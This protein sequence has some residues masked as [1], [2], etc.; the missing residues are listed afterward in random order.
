MKILILFPI[1]ILLVNSCAPK[2]NKLNLNEQSLASQILQE[3]QEKADAQEN[4]LSTGFSNSNSAALRLEENRSI[5]PKN[6]PLVLDI[7]GTRDKIKPVNYSELGNSIE[8]IFLKHPNDSDYFKNGAS[9]LFTKSNIITT[10]EKGIARFDLNGQ[11][12]E[13]I[14]IDG[15]KFIVDEQRGT[16]YVTSKIMDVYVGSQGA[17]SAIGDKIFYKY[18]NNPNEESFLME[19]DVSPGKQSLMM[20]GQSEN[21]EMNGK[22]EIIAQLPFK[23]KGNLTF[24]DEDH[25]ITNQRKFAS[26]KSGVFMTVHSLSGDTVCTLKDYDPVTNFTSSVYRGV[27]SGDSYKL[28]GQSYFRQNFNDTIYRFE[29]TNRIVPV[30]VIDLGEKGVASSEEAITP[31]FS[32]EDK[33]VYNEIVETRG[34]LFFLYTQDYSCPNSARSGSLKYNRFVMNKKTGEQFHAYIDA[35]P[36]MPNKKMTWPRPPQTNVINDLDFGPARWPIMQ[37]E[38][39]LIY[40]QFNGKDIK[41]H[42]QNNRSNTII[43]N[44]DRLENISK[45]CSDNDLLIMVIK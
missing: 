39:G 19:Y 12:I 16:K 8:Y 14:C 3:E 32:L 10:T 30:Y 26:S 31:K 2:K 7:T 27:E 18:V 37:T 23:M 35:A 5:D 17:V 11:F 22:G 40:F 36:Y 6:P 9:I 24:L 1:L 33:F 43:A 20:P 13:M 44:K 38:N 45:N 28:N 42:V 41:E 29:S 34:F 4:K 15:Q 25:W 21:S